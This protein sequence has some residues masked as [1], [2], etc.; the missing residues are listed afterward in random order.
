MAGIEQA[1][2]VTKEIVIDLIDFIIPAEINVNE[3]RVMWAKYE[4][5]NKITLA[6]N[7][8]SLK[9]LVDHFEKCIKVKLIGEKTDLEN[10]QYICA[11][12]YA[13]TKLDDD[14]LINLSAEVKNE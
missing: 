10:S 14:F 11:N 3:F 4:W 5:E 7:I 1:Y 2:L 13:K 12:F 9:D 6:T 8:T